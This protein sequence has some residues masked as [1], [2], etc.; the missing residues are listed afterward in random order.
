MFFGQKPDKN[1]YQ[2]NNIGVEELFSWGHFFSKPAGDNPPPG[3]VLFMLGGWGIRGSPKRP[4]YFNQLL[5][6]RRRKLF[7]AILEILEIH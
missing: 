4:K 5:A 3:V 6:R 2:K 1:P 7:W